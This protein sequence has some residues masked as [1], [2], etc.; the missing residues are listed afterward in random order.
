MVISRGQ[1][2]PFQMHATSLFRNTCEGKT[3]RVLIDDGARWIAAWR[4]ARTREP[5][6]SCQSS[7]KYA[8]V[9]NFWPCQEVCET[10]AE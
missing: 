3:N 5:D 6:S 8:C 2:E 9:F 1:G 10:R 7:L 4:R